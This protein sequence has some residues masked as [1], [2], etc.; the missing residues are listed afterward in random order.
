M[1]NLN[2]LIAIAAVSVALASQYANGAIVASS[3][4]TTAIVPGILASNNATISEVNKIYP[5]GCSR[6]SLHCMDPNWVN[7]IGVLFTNNVCVNVPTGWN[8]AVS[9][10][11]LPAPMICSM[12]K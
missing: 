12:S 4:R 3:P 7:C 8:D 5:K 1:F 2:R 11:S 9:S 10:V 6:W